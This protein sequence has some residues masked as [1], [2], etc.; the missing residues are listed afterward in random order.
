M[1]INQA[2]RPDILRDSR[3]N[4]QLKGVFLL[5]GL[6][7]AGKTSLCKYFIT[8]K[9]SKRKA[10]IY[11]STDES[12]NSVEYSLKKFGYNPKRHDLRIIDCYS[13]RVSMNSN[14]GIQTAMPANLTE[15]SIMMAKA[16]RDL[17]DF[18]L[19]LDSASTLI[20]HAGIPA[21]IS[22]LQ[23][24]SASVKEADG[25]GLVT[26]E[27]GMHDKNVFH[28]LGAMLDGILQIKLEESPSGSI[29]RFF[30]AFSMKDYSHSSD[31]MPFEIRDDG[32]YF[33]MMKLDRIQKHALVGHQTL[34]FTP[35][36]D[37]DFER[38]SFEKIFNPSKRSGL[39]IQP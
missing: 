35:Y 23:T 36:E 20:L 33:T 27:S 7:G 3:N 18:N 16:Q 6:P 37:V 19:V 11:L 28:T 12:S 14:S 1:E 29:M 8:H 17:K 26:L 34:S 39:Q 21:T 22:F 32:V 4:K 5:V 13:W 9:L 25:L 2:E 24:L 15:V 38:S 30:R 10:S 31:W